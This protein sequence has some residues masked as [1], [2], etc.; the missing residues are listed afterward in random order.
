MKIKHHTVVILQNKLMES[1]CSNLG[2]ALTRAQLRIAMAYT[3]SSL[4]VT[5]QHLE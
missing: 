5:V 2:T 4:G 1:M 3:K